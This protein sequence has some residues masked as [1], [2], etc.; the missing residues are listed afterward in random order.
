M[1]RTSTSTSSTSKPPR[2]GGEA[3]RSVGS[4]RDDPASRSFVLVGR[5]AGGHGVK[6]ELRLECFAEGPETLIGVTRLRVEGERPDAPDLLLDV[7][8]LAPAG[9]RVRLRL[10]GV[11]SR[12]AAEALRGRQ[13]WAD[14]GELEALGEGE[15]YG[16]EL[17]GCALEGEDGAALGRVRDVWR[18]GAPDVLVVEAPDGRELLVPAALLR[19]V[20]VPARRAV[21]EVLPG[22]LDP[23]AAG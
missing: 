8:S 19:E 17:I 14:K 23:E 2:S 16:H 15:H 6:G 3:E 21:V 10:A 18:T 9:D 5:L 20:D 12:D 4:R 22:L 1:A 7:Q 13:V 11:D